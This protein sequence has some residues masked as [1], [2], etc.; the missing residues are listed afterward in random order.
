[1]SDLKIS[2]YGI[3]II[4][5]ETNMSVFD[6]KSKVSHNAYIIECDAVDEKGLAHIIRLYKKLTSKGISCELYEHGR[7]S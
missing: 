1:M 5:E 2:V 6:I 3:K 4:R 7:L